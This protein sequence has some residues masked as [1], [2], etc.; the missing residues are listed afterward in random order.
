[1]LL[2]WPHLMILSQ[3]YA[4]FELAPYT[5]PS[6]IDDSVG[7][8]TILIKGVCSQTTLLDHLCLLLAIP[9]GMSFWMDIVACSWYPSR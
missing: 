7:V 5:L 9:N 4:I 3:V 2:Y 8:C 6:A 1:M